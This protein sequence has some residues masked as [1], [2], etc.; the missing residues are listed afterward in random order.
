MLECDMPKKSMSDSTRK[1]RL[2]DNPENVRFDDGHVILHVCP[3]CGKK[4][5]IAHIHTG[6]CFWCGW[7]EEN[8]EE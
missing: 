4:N 8:E 5:W 7:E 3:Q 6:K 2:T 1:I